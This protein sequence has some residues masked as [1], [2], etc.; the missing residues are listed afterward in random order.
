MGEYVK[1]I[2]LRTG[3]HLLRFEFATTIGFGIQI[4]TFGASLGYFFSI[5]IFGINWANSISG[6]REVET[7]HKETDEKEDGIDKI[8]KFSSFGSWTGFG[9]NYLRR[10]RNRGK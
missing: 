4:A 8:F 10:D 2:P 3:F 9:P 1:E 6:R 5:L 7:R